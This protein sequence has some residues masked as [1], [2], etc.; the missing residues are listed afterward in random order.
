MNKLRNEL[1]LLK[2]QINSSYGMGGVSISL[3]D[4]MMNKKNKFFKIQSR[5]LKIK[6]IYKKSL[7]V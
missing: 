4:E 6:R 5:V 2:M 7:G 1:M 3:Y